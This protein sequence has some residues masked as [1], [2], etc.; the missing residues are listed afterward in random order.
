LA[1]KDLPVNDE[2]RNFFIWQGGKP[3]PYQDETGDLF[4]NSLY[5]KQTFLE[6][7]ISLFLIVI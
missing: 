7:F 2:I 1:S 5:S 3:S 4:F 6:I